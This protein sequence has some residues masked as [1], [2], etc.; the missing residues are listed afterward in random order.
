MFDVSDLRSKAAP[1]PPAVSDLR[2]GPAQRPAP[3]AGRVVDVVL[4]VGDNI[5]PFR[6]PS[7]AAVARAPSVG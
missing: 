5:V 3:P 6:R 2:A 7:P 1:L 4:P